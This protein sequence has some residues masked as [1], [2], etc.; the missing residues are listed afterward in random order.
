MTVRLGHHPRRCCHWGVYDFRARTMWIGPGAFRSDRRLRYVARHELAHAWQLGSNHVQT[1]VD[2]M[3]RWG[4]TATITAAEMQAD[5][6]AAEWG[7]GPG[8]YWDCPADARSLA[9][10]RLAGDWATP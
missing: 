9:G 3:H 7:A 6:V 1:V 10:R 8:H 2:D 4:A 5:C